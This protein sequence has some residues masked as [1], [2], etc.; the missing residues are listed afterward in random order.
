[1]SDNIFVKDM[2]EVLDYVYDFSQVLEPNEMITS[3]TLT[4]STTNIVIEADSITE[5]NKSST[6]VLSSG[7]TADVYIIA[8]E[9]TTDKQLSAAPLLFRK[10][11]RRININVLDK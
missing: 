8:C 6:V 5:F 4:E 3:Q 11:K 9:I 7:I 1:M 10:Y 2:A